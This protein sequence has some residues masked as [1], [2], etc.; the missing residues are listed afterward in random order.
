MWV[1]AAAAVLVTLATPALAQRP[2]TAATPA[3]PVAAPAADVMTDPNQIETTANRL[4]YDRER[5]VVEGIGNV[6][7]K[8]GDVELRADYV[9][10]DV[11]TEQAQ[12]F[13]DVTLTR[14]TDVWSGP[15]LDYNFRTGATVSEQMKLNAAPFYVRAERSER[16]EDGR[17]VLY[18]AWASTCDPETENVDFHVT[19]RRME[20]VQDDYLKAKNAIWWFGRVPSMWVPYWYRSLDSDYGFNIEP[21]YASRHG[22]YLKTSYK[23][24]LTPNVKGRTHL[25]YYEKRGVALGQDFRWNYEQGRH[26]GQVKS[27][28]V[29]DQ[30]PMQQ[31]DIDAGRVIEP[32]RYR[33]KLTDSYIITPRDIVL[34]RGQYLSDVDFLEDFYRKEY[35]LERQ[36]DNYVNYTHRG[37]T[38]TAGVLARSRLNDFYSSV[39][40]LPEASYELYQQPVFDTDLYYES[41]TAAA[42]LQQTYEKTSDNEDYDAFRFDTKH[43]VYYPEKAFGFLNYV[44]RAGVRGT[45]YSATPLPIYVVDPDL[46]TNVV[47][48]VTNVVSQPGTGEPRIAGYEDGG[49]DTRG[50]VELGMETS[51]KAFGLYDTAY[52]E[53]R[54]ILE[55]F[56]NYTLIPEPNLTPDQLYQF[57]SVDTVDETHTVRLGTRNKWQEKRETGAFDLA[58][59]EI[60]TVWLIHRE[61]DT[62]PFQ[63]VY[64]DAEFRP[65]DP[66]GLTFDGAY[67]LQDDELDTFNTWLEIW[68]KPDLEASLMHRYRRDDSSLLYGDVTFFPEAKWSLNTYGRYEFEES[69]LDQVGGSIAHRFTCIG[70]KLGGEY[71]PGFTR[72]DGSEQKEEYEFMLEFWLTAFPDNVVGGTASAD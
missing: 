6:V 60:S 10:V 5:G 69:R 58:D 37:D 24:R 14:G 9:R 33:V 15:K 35:R 23:Y 50:V 53:R 21:G 32:D 68:G 55:P 72:T 66:I 57:D 59:V 3:A 17:Y 70:L 2:R 71:L 36:P 43:T 16:L 31:E 61:E 28:Y 65:V 67:S 47:N 44:P 7:L 22:Y 38:Y 45:Y 39:N 12:A 18:N 26:T 49:A 63:F 13:G 8:R 30:E 20:L 56:A 29:D 27:Y 51:Y 64:W 1:G 52:G 48:G 62:D 54:H 40:R 41:L 42:F 19:A 25:D 11:N 4:N 46:I 34:T